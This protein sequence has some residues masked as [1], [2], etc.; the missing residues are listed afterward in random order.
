MEHIYKKNEAVPPGNTSPNTLD[1][2]SVSTYTML[3]ILDKMR[4]ELGLEAMIEY[5]SMYLETIEMHNSKLKMAV[6]EALKVYSTATI[7]KEATKCKEK[8]GLSG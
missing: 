7:Y 3:K 5:L 8:R 4:Q 2:F 1:Q 6:N